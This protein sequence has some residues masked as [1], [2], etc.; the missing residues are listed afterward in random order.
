M[1]IVVPG[2]CADSVVTVSSHTLSQTK[3]KRIDT[4][5][6]IERGRHRNLLS[7]TLDTYSA[8]VC[9]IAGNVAACRCQL[10]QHRTDVL[11][12]L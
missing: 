3:C 7:S 10:N 9:H 4:E 5:T 1:Q 2:N 11:W 12:M 6:L 8:Q